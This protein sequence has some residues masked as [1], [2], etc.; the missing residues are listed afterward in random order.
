MIFNTARN[1]K[2]ANSEMTQIDLEVDFQDLPEPFVPFTAIANDV[3]AHCRALYANAVNGDYGVIADYTPPS[4]IS[5]DNAIA[6]LRSDRN[7]LLEESDVYVLPDRWNTMTQA[8]QNEW[9]TYRQ[10]LRDA[11]STPNGLAIVYCWNDLQD[12]FVPK[13]PFAWP[14]MPS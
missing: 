2:W 5:G 8:K 6:M 12:R 9:S 7:V 1:P 10:L 11:T 13:A 3:E 4:D 14:V